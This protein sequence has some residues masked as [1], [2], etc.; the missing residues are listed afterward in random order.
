MANQGTQLQLDLTKTSESAQSLTNT[1]AKRVVG[2]RKATEVLVDL[3]EAYQAG[4]NQPQHPAGN[5]LFLGPTGSGK[6]HVVE[7]FAKGLFG[8][9]RAML[10]IDC[11]EFQYGHEIAKLVGSPAGYLGHRETSPMFTQKA[12]DQW[13]TEKLK[14]SIVLFDEIEKAS[15]ALWNLMLGILDKAM[16]TLGTNEKVDFSKSLIVMTSNVGSKQMA[17]KGMGF[18]DVSTDDSARLEQIAVGAAKSKFSPEFLNRIQ[19]T[20]T[21]QALTEEQ[22]KEVLNIELHELALNVLYNAVTKFTFAVS[23][24][25]RKTLLKEGYSKEYGAREI[26]RV[27]ERR[28][29]IPLSKLVTSGQIKDGECIVIDEVG[30]ESFAFYNAISEAK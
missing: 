12:L 4:F 30:Q 20:V 26:K 19:H 9:S 15:D 22:A 23:P 16:L 24:S 10:K 18:V 7:T 14:L 25:A 6:T 29:Q 5:V 28:I 8:D 3:L 2:Q 17:N 11:A 13:H 21:F 27:I 1:F